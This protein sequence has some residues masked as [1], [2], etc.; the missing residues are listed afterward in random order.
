MYSRQSRVQCPPIYGTHSEKSVHFVCGQPRLRPHTNVPTPP[1]SYQ[2]LLEDGDDDAGE[3][4]GDDD[5][6]KVPAQIVP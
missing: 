2:E 3:G 1:Y 6:A 5:Y 4:D